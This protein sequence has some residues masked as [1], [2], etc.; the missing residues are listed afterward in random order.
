MRRPGRPFSLTSLFRLAAA[1]VAAGKA[2]RPQGRRRR[3]PSLAC[4]RVTWGVTQGGGTENRKI[5]AAP[6]GSG[7]DKNGADGGGDGDGG[8]G[9]PRTS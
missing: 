7:G 1:R 9:V 5:R 6:T 3:G 8:G 2:A 4:A